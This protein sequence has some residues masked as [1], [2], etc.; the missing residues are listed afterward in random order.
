[1]TGAGSAEA[2]L[3]VVDDEPNIRELLSASL[4][5]AGF[6]VSTAADG[7]EALA[8]A[9][10][11]KPDLLLL[12]VMMPGLDGFEVVKRLRQE[13]NKAPVLFLTARDATEDKI[14][15]LTVGGDDYITK[16][17]SLDEVIARVRAVLRRTEGAQASP[18]TAK[19]TFADIELDSD[20]HEAWKNG[21]PVSLSPTEFKLLRYFMLNAGRVLSK[22]Q[23]LDHV[24]NYDFGGDAN[25]VESY[26]SY[27]RRKLDTTEPRLIHTLRGVGYVLRRSA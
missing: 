22:A 4:R 24:W 9:R 7:H 26:V 21:V 25:V 2:R 16:P 5:F 1:M 15:G 11:V 20:T 18:T 14:S 27:L 10:A 12:D 13:G 8:S 17:F 3:L 23:I 6:E 19:L